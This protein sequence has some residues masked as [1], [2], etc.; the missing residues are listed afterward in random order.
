M[1]NDNL[2]QEIRKPSKKLNLIKPEIHAK[3]LLYYH[4]LLQRH[5]DYVSS[6]FRAS[7][8]PPVNSVQA[9]G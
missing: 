3:W 5:C 1:V 2:N 6:Q 9:N 7:T 4:N 8:Q